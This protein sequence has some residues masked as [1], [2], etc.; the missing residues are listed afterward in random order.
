[1]KPHLVSIYEELLGGIE[2]PRLS[3]AV[4]RLIA[5]SRGRPT[6]FY[7]RKRRWRRRARSSRL[8]RLW[9]KVM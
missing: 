9:N 8:M 7:A 4:E 6:W 1:M 3:A 5:D 2:D